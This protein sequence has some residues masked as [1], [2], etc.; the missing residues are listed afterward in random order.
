VGAARRGDLFRDGQ[1]YDTKYVPDA[2]T[3]HIGDQSEVILEMLS[4]NI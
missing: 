1:W 4:S 2:L 3:V